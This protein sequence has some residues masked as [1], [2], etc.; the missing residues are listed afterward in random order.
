MLDAQNKTHVLETRHNNLINIYKSIQDETVYDDT[1]TYSEL[2]ALTS[3]VFQQI[4]EIETFIKDIAG[5]S[6]D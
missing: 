6:Y 2:H 1:L 5:R 3:A 4:H